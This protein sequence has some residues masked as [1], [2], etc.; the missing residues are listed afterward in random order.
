MTAAAE[1][2]A[3]RRPHVLLVTVDQWPGH[4]L[5]S[6]GHPVVQ[7]PTLDELAA[8]GIRYTRAYSETPVCV[9][10]RRGL[11]TGTTARTHGV[12]WNEPEAPMPDLATLASTFRD[13]GYQTYAVG[14]LHVYPQRDRIGFADVLLTEEG[15]TQWGVVDDYEA[16]LTDAGFHGQAFTHGMGNNQY[17]SRAWHLPE[18]LHVTNWATEQMARQIKRRDPTRPGFFYLSYTHPHPPLVP[19][20]EYLDLY[21]R[22]EMDPPVHG[23]WADD[24]DAA[25]W[26]VCERQR[27]APPEALREDARRAFYALCTHIDHQLRV[28]IGTLREE[29]MLE[30]TVILFT[31]DHGEMLGD[32]GAWAKSLFYEGSARVPM[33]LTGPV[34]DDRVSPGQVDQRLCGLQDVMP[35]LLDLAGIDPP[36]GLDG[37]SVVTG[38]QRGHFTGAVGAGVK[39]TCMA[40][41]DRYKLIYY[42]HGNR[43]Q[44]FDLDVDPA[45]LDDLASSPD[46]QDVLERLS[47]VLVSELGVEAEE[48]TREGKW[49]GNPG[50][51]DSGGSAGP[52]APPTRGLSGQRGLH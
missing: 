18:R 36:A 45:E 47:N 28:V 33:I 22:Q 26:P 14:K 35:T 49:I 27:S 6:A 46:H 30:D 20:A 15:R 5:Q 8:T 23:Q 24:P 44:L 16:A 34:G 9:P 38:A 21:R 7:T 19:P 40:R 52:D 37:R 43:R 51:A 29:G 17:L 13:H 31:S 39:A 2:P 3:A 1:T 25:P 10:A 48:W 4:L 41:D 12:R 42:P 11:M 50:H 32:H